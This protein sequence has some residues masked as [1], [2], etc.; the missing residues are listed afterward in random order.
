MTVAV[1]SLGCD[2]KAA[3]GFP[4]WPRLFELV[5]D[6]SIYL[7]YEM[8]STREDDSNPVDPTFE[9]YRDMC[10]LAGDREFAFDE[11][12]WGEQGA[13]WRARPKFDQD[14][15]RLVPIVTARN[16]C[17]DYALRTGASHLLFIDAD[18]IPPVDV[19]PKLMS[20][21]HTL[22]GGIVPGRGCHKDLKYIFGEEREFSTGSAQVLEVS[23]GTCGCMMIERRVFDR[24]RFRYSIDHGLSEDPAYAADV[25]ALFGEK[26]WLHKGVVCEHIGDLASTEVSQF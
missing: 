25:L 17:I 8:T 18:V 14:Q 4:A 13:Y 16:M 2:R 11:W 19:I 5:G 9:V 23:H 26:M 21:G 3:G 12:Y 24:I 1:A 10:A 7:N 20:L 22:V 15:A 6:Y